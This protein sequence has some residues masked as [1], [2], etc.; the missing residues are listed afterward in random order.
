MSIFRNFHLSDKFFLFIPTRNRTE[1]LNVALGYYSKYS[2]CPKIVIADSSQEEFLS[3]NVKLINRYASRL[4]I[5]HKIYNEDISFLKKVKE[6]LSGVTGFD[7]V[8]I[9][10]DDDYLVLDT[11]K[12]CIR[13]LMASKNHVSAAG[14]LIKMDISARNVE[15]IRKT[16]LP[17]TCLSGNAIIRGECYVKNRK[18]RFYGVHRKQAFVDS[19]QD[20]IY[21]KMDEVDLFTEF[22]LYLSFMMRGK[23]FCVKEVG[24][25]QLIHD[26]SSSKN[27]QNSVPFPRQETY[28]AKK[29]IAVELLSN[30]LVKTESCSDIS[31]A[32]IQSV[33]LIE[34]LFEVS[35]ATM[36]E[37]QRCIKENIQSKAYFVA[38][39]KILNKL[40]TIQNI[41]SNMYGYKPIDIKAPDPWFT[42]RM[43]MR[44][45]SLQR[46][47][48]D[49]K[50]DN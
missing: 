25:I 42:M 40:I 30:W 35:R 1:F 14:A 3:A 47:L 39:Q 46:V 24:Y 8:A 23:F 18:Q 48:S 50:Y 15:G 32:K 19:V 45:S 34:D 38:K 31:S 44:N 11:A 49:I 29:N 33:V 13:F 2:D 27:I 16:I 21:T 20:A 37:R 9:A 26:K 10:A 43:R 36:I 7:F 5:E 28:E 6:G 22:F 17:A 12:K 4:N 41:I